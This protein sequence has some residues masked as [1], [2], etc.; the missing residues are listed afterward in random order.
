MDNWLTVHSQAYTKVYLIYGIL[1]ALNFIGF[2]IFTIYSVKSSGSLE[3]LKEDDP[4]I[5]CPGLKSF[6]FTEEYGNLEYATGMPNLGTTGRLYLNCYTGECRYM[7]NDTCIQQRCYTDD[8]NNTICEDYIDYCINYTTYT[9][10]SCSNQCRKSK[11]RKCG[12]SYCSPKSSSYKYSSS[13][14]SNDDNSKNTTHPKSCNAEN[15]ILYWGNTSENKLYYK[16]VNNTDYKKISYLNNAVT[17]KESCPPG[18]KM[19]G[20]L[21]NLGNKLCYPEYLD[22]PL[23]YITTNK[24]DANYSDVGWV[25][26]NNKTVYFTNEATENGK[27][28]GGF[29]VDSDLLIKYKDEDCVTLE[30][31]TISNLFSIHPYTLYRNSIGYDPYTHREVTDT[32]KRYLKWCVPGVGKEK[33]IAKIKEL[34][35]VFDF[36]VTTNK[37]VINPIKNGV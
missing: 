11:S 14:C 17:A 8:W 30:E 29:F 18:K 37:D 33:N 3:L 35:V 31:G 25:E 26:L 32:G 5:Y 9:E 6:S 36:N 24:S 12:I 19:C 27:I 2:I 1:F 34:K 16:S 22:C 28:I 21:D 20:I 4:D 15:L 13:S 7:T 23:N 10:Y